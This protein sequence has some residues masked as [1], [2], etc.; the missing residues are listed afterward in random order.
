MT[1]KNEI[2]GTVDVLFERV[3]A[4]IEQARRRVITVVNLAE[5]Y[6]K[7]EIGRYIV[8]EEQQGNARA[9]Y[10]K[11][12][13]KELSV[14]LTER[15]GDG[16][17]EETLKKC[18]FFYNAYS[19]RQIG[20]T[21]LT[22]L[23]DAKNSQQCRPNSKTL[24]GKCNEG[25]SFTL[26]W[27]HYLVLMRV[28]NPDARSFYEIECAQ[29]QWSVRQLSRQVGSSLYERLALSRNKNEVMRQHLCSPIP[30]LS[31][32]QESATGKGEEL[33]KRI[34]GGEPGRRRIA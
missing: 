25:I 18:R 14:R 5:V 19:N 32:G 8:E 22:E 2:W 29:Q 24:S 26:S 15:F 34:Q 28:E 21:V 13:L 27:S 30:A 7:Y 6:T 31:A 11:Q 1:Q 3:S 17:S 23:S 4:L 33:D 10:G 16:W 20:S 9:G 12:V